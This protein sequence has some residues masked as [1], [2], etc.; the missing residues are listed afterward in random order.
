[1]NKL[2]RIFHNKPLRLVYNL[3]NVVRYY[4]MPKWLY[5]T[6]LESVLARLEYR[7]DREY[8]LDRVNYNNKCTRHLHVL[9]GELNP[10]EK[11]K[12][13]KGLKSTYFFDTYEYT[14]WFDDKLCWKYLAGDITTV[15]STPCI[16]KSR[17]VH[18]P[19]ANSVVL[20]L[21]KVRH[22]VFL[23]DE[24]PF[25]EKMDRSIFRLAVAGKPHRVR[26]MQMYYGSS[27]CDAGIISHTPEFPAEWARPKISLYDHLCYK[28]IL[29]IEGNDVATNL[30]WIMSSNSVAV[31]PRPT[32]ETWFMEGR[33]VPNYHYIE[34]KSDYSD[35]EERLN[36]YIQYPE[37]AEAI[38]AH[39]HEYVAQFRDKERERLISLLV[40]Q[41][42]FEC[43]EQQS[44]SEVVPAEL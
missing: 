7:A 1:M 10:L 43:T 4:V 21:D 9:T 29:A 36:H 35:L 42:Y 14:R 24:I 38:I 44:S 32:Y 25:R 22:F 13:R 30:K 40:L 23:K 28:F 11:H 2:N 31:M 8:I 34:I 16:V 20:N 33:L 37:Q 39:A 27:C 17:P 26:F 15:P 19:N 18:E 6:R 5:R 3:K 12:F 41:K